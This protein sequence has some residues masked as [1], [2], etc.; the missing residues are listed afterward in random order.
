[1]IQ[2]THYKNFLTVT[3]T[4]TELPA[5]MVKCASSEPDE[6]L[7]VAQSWMDAMGMTDKEYQVLVRIH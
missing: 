1:M 5:T 3:M 7:K 4:E 2:F 6:I